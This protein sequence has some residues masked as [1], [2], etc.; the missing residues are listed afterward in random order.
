MTLKIEYLPCGKLL[1]YAKNSRT[2]SDEQVDQI[3]NS[4]REFGFTNPVLIDE[5]NEIIAGHGRLTAAEVLEIEKIPVIR[6]TGLTPKQ[7]KAYRIADNKLALN[8]GWDMQLLAE[9]VSE[10]VDSDFDIELLGFSDSE[11]DDM[12]NVEPPPSEEDDAPP[13][14]QIKYLTI[15]KDRIPA[16]DTEI[17]LL[18]D[19]YRQYHDAHEAHEGFVKYLAD[20]CQ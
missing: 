14:V 8:A 3:V 9:E 15:D 12:L 11:I 4:I 13:I 20:R 10:L 7:K 17:A 16:T 1:R 19:V 2:H 5:D 6:L 18:L